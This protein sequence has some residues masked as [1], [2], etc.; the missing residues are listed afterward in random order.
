MTPVKHLLFLD[1]ETTGLN[2][3]FCSILEVAAVVVD[4]DT[5]R[6][7]DTYQAVVFQPNDKIMAEMDDWCTNTHTASGLVD[8]VGRSPFTVQQVDEALHHFTRKHF[9]NGKV[10]LAGN[11]VHFDL[12]F[13]NV[14]MPRTA[15]ILSH[16]LVD[17]S[18]M[19]RTLRDV[20]G[21]DVPKP[22]GSAAH[23]ATQDVAWSLEQL[24]LIKE[25]LRGTQRP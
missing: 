16:Q 5:L 11:S 8:E 21:V 17:V 9:P 19:A 24:R 10:S 23:R 18:G 3:K 20:V 6:V 7:M 13:I 4:S 12:G 25:A 22:E 2:P 15:S 1:L 14:H